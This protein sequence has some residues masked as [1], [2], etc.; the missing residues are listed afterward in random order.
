MDNT[1]F[2]PYKPYKP[3]NTFETVSMTFGVAS[4]LSCTYF[5]LSFPL[6][7]L[8]I[9]FALLSRGGKMEIS[10]RATVGLSLGCIGLI[11]TVILYIC[12][13]YI[14]IQEYGSFENLLR[15]TCE[16]MGYDFEALFGDVF[17]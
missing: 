4:I 3:A 13:F 14:G 15:E 6:A 11:V 16:M 7:A 2:N 9:L 10:T 8:A 1:N 5:F 12:A 17:Q